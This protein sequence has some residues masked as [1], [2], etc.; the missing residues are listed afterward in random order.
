MPSDFISM[1]Q[2]KKNAFALPVGTVGVDSGILIS[3]QK[4]NIYGG[5]SDR[6]AWSGSSSRASR[7]TSSPPR[8]APVSW[9]A[10]SGTPSFRGEKVRGTASGESSGGMEERV[11]C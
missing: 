7:G 11:V 4:G 2:L 10:A 8:T 6:P 1:V 3:L 5:L 9:R